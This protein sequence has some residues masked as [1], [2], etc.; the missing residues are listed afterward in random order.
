MQYLLNETICINVN[1]SLREV[2]NFLDHTLEYYKVNKFDR[3]NH[4]NVIAI[5]IEPIDKANLNSA[6]YIG[7][8]SVYCNNKFYIF[9]S[10]KKMIEVP[11]DQLPKDIISIE[12][13]SGCDPSVLYYYIVEEIIRYK[14]I[15][16]KDTIMLHSSAVK[17]KDNIIVFPAW[18]GTGKTNLVLALM[19]RGAEF[20]SDDLLFLNNYG[21]ATPYVKP[22]NL[23][24]YNLQWFP[25]IKSQIGI[26]K[27]VIIK[28]TEVIVSMNNRLSRFIHPDNLFLK[29]LKIIDKYSKGITNIKIPIFKLFPNIKI[30]QISEVDSII[31]IVRSDTVEPILQEMDINKFIETMEGCHK[32]EWTRFSTYQN[33]YQY[34]SGNSIS[35]DTNIAQKEKQILESALK[36][37]TVNTLKIPMEGMTDKIFIKSIEIIENRLLHK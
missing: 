5:E 29:G 33:M 17:Y 37:R 24:N 9:D 10:R 19:R 3:N 26:K 31:H 8:D 27:K 4:A 1:S 11:F 20:Y 12:V 15:T 23:F 25:D 30:G 34:L 32:E 14:L 16:E 21:Y 28:T 2:V 35:V 7:N 13:E 18:G 36:N 22:L 6:R